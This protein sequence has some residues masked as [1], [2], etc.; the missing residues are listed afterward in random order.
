[1]SLGHK[2]KSFIRKNYERMSVKKMARKLEVQ[3]KDVR[4]A[5]RELGL[6]DHAPG[7]DAGKPEPK[8][9]PALYTRISAMVT[10]IKQP[11]VALP[12]VCGLALLLRVV[13]FIEVSDTPFSLQLHTDPWMYDHWARQI[14]GGDWAGR[15]HPV[16]Y[17]GPA[18]PYFLA[19]IYSMFGASTLAACMVQVLLSAASAGLVY[20]LG[21]RLFGPASGLLAG[22][23][24]AIYPMFIFYSGLILSTTLIIFLDLLALSLL[25]E[26]MRRPR[27]YKWILAG[28]SLGLSACARGNVLLF[29]PLAALAVI[30]YF[31][32]GRWKTWL[33]ACAWLALAAIAAIAP[34]SLHN[35]LVGGDFVPL[36]SN[37]GANF[38]IGNN[39]HSDGIY[40]RSPRYKNRP[41]GLS[42]SDQQA[43][44]PAVARQELGR[45]DLSPSEVSSFWVK[46][47]LEEIGANPGPWLRLVGN[48]LKY[49][50]NAYEVPNNRNIYFS[51]RFSFILRLPLPGWGLVFPLA[52]VGMFLSWRGLRK[53]F[54]LIG[55]FAAHLL[56]LLAF[57]VNA[58]YRLVVAPVLIIYAAAMLRWLFVNLRKRRIKAVSLAAVFLALA[59]L[60]SYQSVPRINYRANFL[61]LANAYR[62]LGEPER[63]IENSEAAKRTLRR[64]LDMARR[65]NDRLNVQRIKS[66]LAGITRQ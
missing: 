25:V 51:K 27:F 63:A 18:Y 53:R 10:V 41:M 42:V 24:A 1:M 15:Q 19:A 16:Y 36:T 3:P 30:L 29:A 58:R 54:V 43:D 40:M 61:N 4:R 66:E 34:V 22:L 7:Q 6:S 55:F 50:V 20:H 32:F 56:A 52:L 45:D 35:Y 47:T 38:F 39:S 46:K 2:Q 64:A 65:N 14:A 23:L 44:F 21:R 37:V 11:S 57:F 8:S 13:H 59:Y 62:D 12:V 48:K 60:A 17:L 26:G 33:P 5:L 49:F 31:G 9:R 28:V